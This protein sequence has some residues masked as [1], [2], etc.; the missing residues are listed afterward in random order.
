[1]NKINTHFLALSGILSGITI[2]MFFLGLYIPFLSVIMILGIPFAATLMGLKANI[3]YSL[4]Y[5][6]ATS[7]ITSLINFQESLFFV[8]P[9]LITGLVFGFFIKRKTHCIAYLLI[10]SLISM[11][12]QIISIKLIDFIYDINFLE[13]ISI[14]FNVDV[15]KITNI[16]ITLFFLL[17]LT[18]NI[19]VFFLLEKE[20]PK[21]GFNTKEDYSL[22]YPL[23]A[24]STIS[25]LLGIIL[26]NTIPCI[27]HLI[28]SIGIFC[29]I[30]LFIYYL[31]SG[32]KWF[33]YAFIG[34][35]IINFFLFIILNKYLENNGYYLL[36]NIINL[37]MCIIG[38][39]L[40]I[41]VLVIRKEKLNHKF[42]VKHT[43][44]IE[45]GDKNE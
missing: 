18:Q 33:I 6:F 7:L 34:S 22:Y 29:L 23:L 41:D 19:L 38:A 8:I 10:T 17:G 27:A 2:I 20:L 4:I 14:F 16:Y 37:S 45:E 30:N 36:F 21:F 39:I 35:I 13:T 44:F 12:F 1:M 25:S 9:S 40:I 32:S 3:K 5:I 43:L 31:K 15:S 42:F 24:M 11:L 26:N 28:T